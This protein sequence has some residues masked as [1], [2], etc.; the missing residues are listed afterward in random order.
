MG[1]DIL[2]ALDCDE[3]RSISYDFKMIAKMIPLRY[4]S[5]ANWNHDS[6]RAI[7]AL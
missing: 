5:A 2:N 3:K 6:Q 4:L 7:E 1:F